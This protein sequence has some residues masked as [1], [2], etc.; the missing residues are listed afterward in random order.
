MTEGSAQ[1]LWL[2]RAWTRRLSLGLVTL[3]TA[4][5]VFALG[6]GGVAP[7]AAPAGAASPADEAAGHAMEVTAPGTRVHEA[8]TWPGRT[9]TA[10]TA[11]APGSAVSVTDSP[12][13]VYF[14]NPVTGLPTTRKPATAT[15]A[16]Y[17][18]LVYASVQDTGATVTATAKTVV[19]NTQPEYKPTNDTNWSD[20]DTYIGWQF[21]TTAK[22]TPAYDV[23]FQLTNTGQYDGVLFHGIYV[24]SCNVHLSYSHTNGYV[25]EFASACLGGVTTFSWNVLSHYDST[26]GDVYGQV[27]IGKVLPDVFDNGGVRYAPTVVAGSAG[28]SANGY[29]LMASDGGVFDFGSAQFFGS[30]GSMHLNQPVVGGAATLD[31]Q[32]YWLVASD[33]GIFSFGDARFYGSTGSMHLNKPIV[34]MAV[35]PAGDGY[36]LVA[37]DGGVFTFGGAKFYGSTGGMHLNAPIVGMAADPSGDGYWLVASDGG[38]FTFGNIPFYGSAG[39]TK[40]S[41]PVVGMAAQ[42]TGK[43]YWLATGQGRVYAYGSA[44]SYGGAGATKLNQP[45]LGISASTAGGYW[46]VASDGGVFSFGAARFFGSTGAIHLN[47]PIVGMAVSS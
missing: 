25:A 19:S 35:D 8:P 1:S 36:W 15:W 41:H 12:G 18:D 21:L 2:L 47:K 32:G 33:G 31:G 45:V 40:L 17:A 11:A 23:Y 26:P 24:V 20:S 29:R 22:G 5:C 9:E 39:A 6:V 3:A 34:G 13:N 37:S 42:P 7:G 10:S 27:A 4:S 43:G 46:M 28:S 38:I 14:V 16:P 30:M 44:L